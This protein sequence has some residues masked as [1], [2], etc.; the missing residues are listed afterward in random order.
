MKKILIVFLCII[1]LIVATAAIL[2]A[3]FKDDIKAAIDSALDENLNARAYF[4]A[5]EFGITLFSHFPNPTVELAD[6]GIVG[7]DKFEGDTL[8]AVGNFDITV[9]L[10]SLFG[11]KPQVKSLNLDDA[12]INILVLEDGSANYDIAKA[13]E[14]SVVEEDTTSSNMEI[15]IES[16]R[17]TN[18]RIVYSDKTLPF[19]LELKGVDH[20]G[21]GDFT[22][23]VFDM[24]TAS[25][26]ESV[27]T[28]FDGITYLS[29]QQLEADLTLNMDLANMNFT[30][31]ENNIRI[32][33]FPLSFDGYLAMPGDDMELDIKF[34]T[35]EAGIKSLYSLIPAA[36]TEGYDDIKAEGNL[37]FSGF[38]KGVYNDNSIPAFKLQLLAE[39]GKIQYPD[40]PTA[41][42]NINLDMLVNCADGNIDNTAVNIK[43]FHLDFGKNPVDLQMVIK[44]LK[45]Y[46]MTADLQ[47]SLNLGELNTM[48][49]MEGLEMRG[50]YKI[51]LKANG[52]YDSV[53]QIIPSLSGNMSLANGYIKSSELPKALEDMNFQSTL[54]CPSGK[55]QDFIL[56]VNDFNVKMA[57]EQFRANL[58]FSNLANY[59][60]DLQANGTLDLAMINEYYP[61]EGMSYS[62]KLIAD[63]D[64]KGKFSDVEAERYD[65]LPTS[66]KAEL[67]NFQYQSADLPED[68][69]INQSTVVFNPEKIEIQS[70]DS[71]MGTSDFKVKGHLS[72]YLE[73]ALKDDAI[74]RGNMTLN[75][76]RIDLNEFMSGEETAAEESDTI[77]MEV[78]EVPENID[79]TFTSDIKKIYYDDLQ[80]NNASGAIV[81]K[82]GIVDMRNLG[83]GLFNGRV[84]L[85][86][87]YNTSNPEKPA[88]DYKLSIKEL[89]IPQSF[90]SFEVVQ[91]FAPFARQMQ[92]N[93][94]T[95]FNISGLL[96]E[97]MTP[98]LATVEGGGIIKI[99]EAA[100][101]NS[102]LISGIN[103]LTN[104]NVASENLTLK[105]VIMS[106]QI[107][108][109]RASVKPFSINMGENA[110]KIQGSIGLDQSLDYTVSTSIETG[111]AG[112]ALNSF[113]ASQLGQKVTA[114]EAN[115]NF[116]VGG[117]FADPNIKI[118][119]IDYGEGQVQAAA[120]KEVEQAKEE[121]EQKVEE[122]KEEI[123]KEAEKKA[124]EEA[125]KL[126][127]EAEEKLGEEGSKAAEKTKEEAEKII[128]NLFK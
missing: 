84:V 35:Q 27:T 95:D 33:D 8:V 34:A 120:E 112:A 28:S 15:G 30:F 85:N 77:P 53:K 107:S 126:K 127:K 11:D 113:L 1:V 75:S 115:I 57:E 18:S 104:L 121:V 103:S 101:K 45:D 114:T 43:K 123:R 19:Y 72:N 62:G 71:R 10:F 42:T 66:G 111:K 81:V 13:A 119:S 32:N 49:P 88:F 67:R 37:S 2:P 68:F 87:T 21:K 80:L 17:L 26:I 41:L 64:T 118:K 59:T 56:K 24:T 40:L 7:I 86:G 54:A 9:S 91:S 70:F 29:G 25:E 46:D 20:R 3:I 90:T 97:D 93:F 128:N 38:V 50:I 69:I 22:L 82:D 100:I 106:A 16:W 63:I 109:G 96:A 92:G 58:V 98:K 73:Y 124:E 102:K 110:A 44:N 125:E 14:D 117:T 6:F 23:D 89:S 60:W 39:N 61:I 79:F 47:A 65:R 78:I 122:K 116:Q 48:F 108:D 36:F 51:D 105:D 5:D 55:M 76:T 94:S 4:D 12:L 31:K 99:A 83:F 52:V 74:I